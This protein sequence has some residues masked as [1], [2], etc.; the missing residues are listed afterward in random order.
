MSITLILCIIS[1]LIPSVG[2]IVG[3]FKQRKKYAIAIDEKNDLIH[4]LQTT[5]REMVILQGEKNEISRAGKITKKNFDNM[6]DDE[7]GI[8]YANKLPNMPRKSRR[9]KKNN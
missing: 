6:S 1:F 2:G 4:S 3:Y 7:L 9:N 5:V 8:S